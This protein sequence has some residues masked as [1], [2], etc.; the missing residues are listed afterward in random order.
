MSVSLESQMIKT[1][2]LSE[3]KVWEDF[4]E[5]SAERTPILFLEDVLNVINHTT[6]LFQC[7][8]HR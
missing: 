6:I 8:G 1:E 5:E 7:T 3:T 4:T 2:L